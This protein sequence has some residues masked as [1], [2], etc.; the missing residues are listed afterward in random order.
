MLESA[1][2]MLET[3][4]ALCVGDHG[5][6]LC[7]RMV[8]GAWLTSMAGVEAVEEALDT[9]VGIGGGGHCGGGGGGGPSGS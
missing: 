6:A 3:S 5:E 4:P 1:S 2:A 9:M 7:S 8:C